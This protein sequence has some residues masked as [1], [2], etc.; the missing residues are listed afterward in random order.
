MRLVAA[1]I[2]FALVGAAQQPPAPTDFR[3]EGTAVDA[4]T[5]QPLG[6]VSF[7]VG[8]GRNCC[9][10]TE[11]TVSSSA[12]GTFRIPLKSGGSYALWASRDGYVTDW[13]RSSSCMGAN[14]GDCLMLA[15]CSPCTVTARLHA[16]SEFSGRVV[17]ADTK[18][19]LPK[20]TVE[21]IRVSYDSGTMTSRTFVSVLSSRDGEFTL[22]Q[23][24]P[25]QY[26]FRFTPAQPGAALIIPD[27]NEPPVRQF[28]PRWWPGDAYRNA[29]PFAVVAG[30]VLRLP[31]IIIP[32]AALYRISGTV[33]PVACKSENAY[34]VSIGRQAGV[35]VQS[36]RS[37]VVGCGAEFAFQ[38]LA[39][40]RYQISLLPKE[41]GE[42]AFKE[43]LVVTDR[44]LQRDLPPA[45][46]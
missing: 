5:G 6:D 44:D 26:F 7:H 41:P 3:I 1:T 36:L 9:G 18:E 4:E 33:K 46:P 21:A 25:G 43:D 23:L 34:A 8:A 37:M 35:T 20:V 31:D 19:P 12:D 32:A 17:A 39:P 27:M 24:T 42:A 40:G 13:P 30:T 28:V 22:K 29:S 2:L 14:P 11:A 38:D 45:Q 16:A 15:R 10:W